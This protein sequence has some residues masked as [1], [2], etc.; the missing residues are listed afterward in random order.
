MAMSTLLV[1]FILFTVCLFPKDGKKK[2]DVSPDRF[3]N[4]DTFN[5]IFEVK[6]KIPTTEL[7]KNIEV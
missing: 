5:V 1:Y 3:G 7:D 2:S 6:H 4:Q